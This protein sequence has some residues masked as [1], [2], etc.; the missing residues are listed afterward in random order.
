[1]PTIKTILLQQK[2]LVNNVQN[3]HHFIV[4]QRKNV[5]NVHKTSLIS[6]QPRLFVLHV[7]LQLPFI[8]LN[9][10]HATDAHWAHR[11]L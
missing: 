3:H 7:H 2:E 1:M 11:C 4:I 5:K 6:T 9:Q 8:I 10:I